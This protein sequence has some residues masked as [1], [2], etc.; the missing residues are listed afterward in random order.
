[1]VSASESVTIEDDVIFGTGCT[2]ID[3]DHTHEPHDN[4]LF[5]PAVTAPV[6]IGRGTWLGDRV[7][8]LKGADIGVRCTIGA[9]SVVRGRIPDYSVA[10]GVPARVVG[11]TLELGD[12]VAGASGSSPTG[13]K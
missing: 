7:T 4:V 5:N 11:S 1:M 10:V 8:V 9:G 3:S 2:V 6:R 13:P 12:L